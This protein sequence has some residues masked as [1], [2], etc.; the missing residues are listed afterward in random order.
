MARPSRYTQE[1]AEDLAVIAKVVD[2]TFA[3][4]LAGAGSSYPVP[5]PPGANRVE[6]LAVVVGG[7]AGDLLIDRQLS[8]ANAESSRP[9]RARAATLAWNAAGTRTVLEI[10]PGAGRLFASA[11]GLVGAAEMFATLAFWSE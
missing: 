3:L 11:T 1:I 8:F 6:I 10:P 4:T 7:V 2:L 5:I 9:M